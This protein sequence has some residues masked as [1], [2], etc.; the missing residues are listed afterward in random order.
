MLTSPLMRVAP[1]RF[2]PLDNKPVEVLQRRLT[3]RFAAA[4]PANFVAIGPRHDR[5][6][7]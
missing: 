1:R 6:G 7:R 4:T 5:L 3:R 2:V